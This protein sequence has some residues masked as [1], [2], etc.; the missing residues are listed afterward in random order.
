[1]RGGK[2]YVAYIQV[3][4][5]DH[6]LGTACG[7]LHPGFG[8]TVGGILIVRVLTR[9]RLATVEKMKTTSVYI[10]VSFFGGKLDTD[11]GTLHPGLCKLCSSIDAGSLG[12]V[13]R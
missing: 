5:I 9:A 4:F 13:E 2:D 1:M 10:Q 8:K 11:C 3:S 12:T 6:H 7:T